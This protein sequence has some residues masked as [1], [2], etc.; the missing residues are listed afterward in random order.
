MAAS[1]EQCIRLIELSQQHRCILMVG[2]TYLYSPAVTKIKE[3][4][5]S[6][7]I[8]KLRYI[9]SRRLNLGLYH[10]DVNV[11]WDLAPH[12]L[13]IILYIMNQFPLEVNCCGKTTLQSDIQDVSNMSLLFADG[14]FATIHDSWLDPRKVR[15]MAIVGDHKMIVYNDLEPIEKIRIYDMRV[16]PP[17]YTDTF[18]DFNVSYHYGD[19]HAPYINKEEPLK[20]EARHFVDC[21][22]EN[23]HPLTCGVSGLQLVSILEAASESMHKRGQPIRLRN[24]F[25]SCCQV[26]IHD[27]HPNVLFN[28]LDFPQ[29]NFDFMTNRAGL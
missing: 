12:D 11:A 24:C 27:R 10:K 21:I 7:A 15:D 25:P 26:C 23:R 22:R 9:S 14:G 2:H 5:D 19:M 20:I 3:I 1:S 29:T 28:E 8:G 13:S 18:R 16:D 6:G 4:V 17:P